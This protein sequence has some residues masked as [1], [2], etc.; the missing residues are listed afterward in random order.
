MKSEFWKRQRVG[1]AS[2]GN[3]LPLSSRNYIFGSKE[4]LRN[5]VIS[6]TKSTSL[7]LQIIIIHSKPIISSPWR[8]RGSTFF[9][10]AG[11]LNMY[12]NTR[13]HLNENLLFNTNGLENVQSISSLIRIPPNPPPPSYIIFTRITSAYWV[14]EILF[15]RKNIFCLYISRRF[16]LLVKME[17]GEL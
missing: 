5:V 13:R 6:R 2:G 14:F 16:L 17:H 7:H 3:L 9:P 15:M 12:Q 8:H 4:S 11:K 10:N 1:L